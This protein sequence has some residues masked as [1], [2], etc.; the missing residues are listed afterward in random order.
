MNNTVAG[1][2]E[3]FDK[4]YSSVPPRGTAVIAEENG[5]L[6]NMVNSMVNTNIAN[7]RFEFTKTILER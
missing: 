5:P 3:N 2:F 1:K 4:L 7:S 6:N